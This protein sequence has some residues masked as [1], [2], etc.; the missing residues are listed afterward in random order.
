MLD[1]HKTLVRTFIDAVN[2]ANWSALDS[3]VAADVVRHQSEGPPLQ[4][5][6][7]LKQFL[8]GELAV[9]PD[10]EE[11]VLQLIAE[12]NHVAA[13]LR[14][15]GTQRGALGRFPPTGRRLEADFMCLFR[16]ADGRVAELWPLWD[17]LGM[18][19]QLGHL[20]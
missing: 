16:L 8:H 1:H 19:R 9:F 3:L 13:R 5:L 12:G 11:T 20:E 14:F 17:G 15:V 10:A 4:G 18:L 2:A 7:A 6:A